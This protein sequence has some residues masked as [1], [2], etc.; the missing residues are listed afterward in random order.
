MKYFL[1]TKPLRGLIERLVQSIVMELL[2]AQKDS[3][4]L[5]FNK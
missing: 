3:S 1:V 5:K 4:T 2:I